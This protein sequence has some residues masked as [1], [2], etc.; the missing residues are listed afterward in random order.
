MNALSKTLLS[1]AGAS[2]A[3]LTLSPAASAQYK[4]TDMV[5]DTGKDGTQTEAF[6]KNAWGMASTATSPIWISDNDTGKSTLY[7][8]VNSSSGVSTIIASLVVTI[9]SVTNGQPGSPTGMVA[10]PSAGA[11]TDFS[12]SATV[13][14]QVKTARAA[15]IWATLDGTISGWNPGVLPTTAVIA[16]DRS[17]V[18]ASYTGLT[19]ASSG[20][21]NYLYA[22]D[23]GP[24]RRIDV[25]DSSFNLHSFSPDAF[26]D[27]NIPRTFTPY[28]IE[29]ICQ[30]ADCNIWV[31]YTSLGKA[32]SG[33]VSE[34]T[35]DGTLVRSMALSGPM[36]S[37]WG[38]ALAPASGFGPMSGALLISNNTSR[39]KI[40]AYDPVTG[41]FLGSLRD[42]NGKVIEIDQLWGIRF[43][44]GGSNGL[45][46]ELF[47]TAGSNEYGDGLFGVI[48]FPQ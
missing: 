47:F 12:V 5:T 21:H 46:N 30:G 13:N 3:A 45:P 16:K 38:V 29:R 36:H 34:F 22:A 37:P 24:N 8:I 44:I 7:T 14:G 42:A 33:F 40:D 20:G 41:E 15:F 10:N 26:V 28:G 27:P 4:R 23:G 2:L 31:T 32:Q 9:P 39:G 1:L 25:F 17:D 6:L 43:G 48:T 19:T 35:T 18:A 11:S